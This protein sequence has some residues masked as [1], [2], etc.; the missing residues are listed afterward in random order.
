MNINITNS[1]NTHIHVKNSGTTEHKED[2]HVYLIRNKVNNKAYVG[3]SWNIERRLKEHFS[4]RGSSLLLSKAIVR[5]G[6]HNF[7]VSVLVT[8]QTQQQM[9]TAETEMIKQYDTFVPKGYNLTHGGKGHADDLE[10]LHKNCSKPVA[11]GSSNFCSKHLG[12]P[13]RKNEQGRLY[14]TGLNNTCV[15]LARSVRDGLCISCA[16]RKGVELNPTLKMLTQ[17]DKHGNFI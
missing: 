17:V 15:A 11:Y 2:G 13:L 9:D 6:L 12:P 7:D 4:S 16:R 14:C 8:C 3:Q 1:T 10:C 5:Y